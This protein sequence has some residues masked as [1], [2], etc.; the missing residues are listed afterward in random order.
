MT[1]EISLRDKNN[2]NIIVEDSVYMLSRLR[3]LSFFQLNNIVSC[4][5]DAKIVF[6]DI[7]WF[8]SIPTE[9]LQDYI[10]QGKL[11]YID[12]TYELHLGP[13]ILS[14]I[15]ELKKINQVFYF[16]VPKDT[17]AKNELLNLLFA[18]GLNCF[19]RQ[20]FVDCP[21]AYTPVTEKTLPPKKFLCLNGKLYAERAYLVSLLA[22][23]GLLEYGYVSF[24]DKDSTNQTFTITDSI[25]EIVS[26]S[27]FSD[28]AK[29]TIS[30]ELKKINLPLVADVSIFT[31]EV[32]H[33]RE[34][35][36]SL[37]DAVDF[38]IV[39]ETLGSLHYGNFF[40]T[41][42]TI[43]CILTNKKFIPVASQFFLKKLKEYY[44]INLNKDISHLTDW[45]DTSY[46]EIENIE[47][48]IKKIV[49]IVHSHIIR[50]T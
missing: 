24:F 15:N 50:E 32:S 13:G 42:K 3:K 46:D 27:N 18:R 17:D 5:D 31:S 9:T 14:K 16:Y 30:E 35:N 20:Y 19:P 34:F 40:A 47:E 11:I 48:R 36:A 41:E 33:A 49:Q 39:P 12:S 4:I 43:K 21:T 8:L 28:Q 26:R 25:Q 29:E 22:K 45:C 23:N 1:T 6:F 2:M 44:K 10:C 7:Y 37:Y 38:V